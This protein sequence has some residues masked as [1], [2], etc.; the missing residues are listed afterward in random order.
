MKTTVLL[1]T[2]ASLMSASSAVQFVCW[3]HRGF[4][5]AGKGGIDWALKNRATDLGIPGGTKFAWRWVDCP[6]NEPLAVMELA[7]V[8]PH[9][10]NN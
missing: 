1:T 4:S 6:N 3:G 8:L 2:F 9:G 5:N 10:T 7:S